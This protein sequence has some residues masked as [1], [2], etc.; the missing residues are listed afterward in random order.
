[1]P[2]LE[3]KR[4]ILENKETATTGDPQ[5]LTRRAYF[6]SNLQQTDDDTYGKAAATEQFQATIFGGGAVNQPLV[7]KPWEEQPRL[8][9]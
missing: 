3:V 7:K 9:H 8:N 6:A 5:K 2:N 4:L 1:L